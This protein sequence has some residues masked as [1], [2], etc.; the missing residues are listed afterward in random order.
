VNKTMRQIAQKQQQQ[1]SPTAGS[2]P[3]LMKWG[4]IV[5]QSR[6]A[7]L[8]SCFNTNETMMEAVY[9]HCLGSLSRAGFR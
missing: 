6:N 7:S 2:M 5:L 1:I 4:G 3:V 9:A 8:V